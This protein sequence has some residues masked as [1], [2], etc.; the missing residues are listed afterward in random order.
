MKQLL[1]IVS[2]IVSIGS[3]FG[4]T[5]LELALEA[6]INSPTLDNIEEYQGKFAFEKQYWDQLN[7]GIVQTNWQLTKREKSLEIGLTTLSR[8]KEILY[9]QVY[10]WKYNRDWDGEDPQQVWNYNI[11]ATNSPE[12][13]D[14]I[15]FKHLAK[16]PNQFTFGYACS[17]SGS[18]PRDGQYMLKLV[19]NND[20]CELSSWLYSINPLFQA[21]AYLG[22]KLIETDGA[23][24]DQATLEQMELV[25]NSQLMIYYCSG[26]TVWEHRPVKELVSK[27]EI[28]HFLKWYE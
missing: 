8:N 13:I 24:L 1:I 26:C 7:R 2:F 20:I 19:A 16:L 21:Y 23:V 9:A 27:K 15:N 12:D 3:T 11:I 17:V 14:S 28:K 18:M 4:Q 6:A 22:F 5:D 10:E 25:A